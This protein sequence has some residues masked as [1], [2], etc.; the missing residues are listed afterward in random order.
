MAEGFAYDVFLSHSSRDKSAVRALAERLRNDGLRVWFDDWCIDPGAPIDLAIEKGLENSR[1]LVLVMSPHAFGSDWVD[2]ERDAALFRDPANAERRFIPLLLADCQISDV[3]KRY[4]HIDYREQSET[5]YRQLL[6]ACQPQPLVVGTRH[7]P[8]NTPGPDGRFELTVQ[9]TV[10]DGQLVRKY[11]DRY[12]FL[13]DYNSPWRPLE[14]TLRLWR[15][16]PGL[17]QGSERFQQ[18]LFEALFGPPDGAKVLTVLER[19]CGHTLETPIYEPIRLRIHTQDELLAELPWHAT[20]WQNQQLVSN[21]WTFE[22]VA[23]PPEE[24]SPRYQVDLQT[25]FPI[26]LLVPLVQLGLNRTTV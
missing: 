14:E 9:L 17:C 25:P 20:R 4:K 5:A 6:D 12:R 1:C 8:P 10:A 7:N 13:D 18:R 19:V 23:D 16:D 26:L 24:H 2:L 3:L 21:G 22:L 15:A 11:F